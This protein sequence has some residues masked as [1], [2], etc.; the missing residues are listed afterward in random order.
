MA[1]LAGDIE[2][3]ASVALLTDELQLPCGGVLPNRLVKA[4][5][6]EGLAD[7]ENNVSDDLLRLY[8]IWASNNLG[9]MLT[10]NVQVDR[11]HLERPGNMVIDDATDL[12]ALAR[13]ASAGTEHGNHFWV[14]L[15]H[16]GRQTPASI[17]PAPHAPSSISLPLAEAGCGE[18][19]AMSEEEIEL[20]IGRFANAA[21][22]CRDVGFTGVQIHAAHGYLISQFLSPLANQR[23]DRWGGSLE[24]RARL[25]LET[26]RAVRA[27]V[28]AD[29]PVS[30]K[31]NSADFQRGGFDEDE[32]LMVASWLD[33]ESIDLLEISG[34]NYEQMQMVGLGDGHTRQV[35]A[36]TKAREAYFLE[37]AHRVKPL[38]RAPLM[39]TG[40]MRTVSSMN[41]AIAAGDCDL[42]GIGRPLCAHPLSAGEVLRGQAAALP[43][44]EAGLC[45]AEGALGPEVDPATFKRV[46]SFALLGWY[47]MQVMRIGRGDGVDLELG[48][49][50]ALLAYKANEE[51]AAAKWTRPA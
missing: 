29:F 41:A 31:L 13:L 18:A 42:I 34:G 4:A 50:D 1:D 33:A 23:T 39:I 20:V 48:V 47:C 37:Y 22:V 11:T 38:F 32:S 30:V 45:L 7:S 16:S 9:M 51:K 15:N 36:S 17:N 26:I 12:A 21:R 10:G 35:A 46:E 43:A 40:G 49:L 8:G 2:R 44:V 28:G 25:L 3:S 19:R 24:N 5:M 6:T 14:Q 27:A